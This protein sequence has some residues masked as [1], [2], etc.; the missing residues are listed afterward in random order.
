VNAGKFQWAMMGW[1]AANPHPQGSFIQ[2]L[3]TFN[4]LQTTGGGMNYPLT[5][6]STDFAAL[7]NSMGDGFDTEK[8]KPSVTAASLAFNDL[9]PIVPLWERYG[10]NPVNEKKRVAPWPADSDTVYKNGSGDS[11]VSIMLYNGTLHSL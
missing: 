2:N 7:I 5:Q 8:Q 6:G 10:N 9:L 1:G 11:F 4:T 3:Q